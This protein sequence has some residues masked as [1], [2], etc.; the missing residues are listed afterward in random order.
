MGVVL[1]N[2][3]LYAEGMRTTVA[4]TVLSF[5]LALVIG[6]AVATCRVSPVPPLRLAGAVW[7]EVL[8]NTPLLALTLLFFFGFPKIGIRFSAFPSGVI[9]LAAYTSAFVAET[10]RAGIATVPAG[11]SEAARALGLTFPG[12]LRVVVLPQ[13]VRTVVAPLGSVFIALIKNS[14][15]ISALSVRELVGISDQLNTDTA[16][17]V[18]VFLGTAVAYLILTLGSGR[19]IARLERKV[20]ILR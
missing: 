9:V 3:G 14:A 20:A 6:T 1:D 16:R 17:P 4:L 18:Q 11:Q 13:A 7:V 10:V 12:V 2:L 5:A 8:R 15:I 19:A